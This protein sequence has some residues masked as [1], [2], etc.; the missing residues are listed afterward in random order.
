MALQIGHAQIHVYAEQGARKERS[1]ELI[2]L[3]AC[4]QDLNLRPSD[5]ETDAP[6]IS[7]QEII[8]V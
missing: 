8:I 7:W 5:Y 4:G 3:T 2:E 6:L 1:T